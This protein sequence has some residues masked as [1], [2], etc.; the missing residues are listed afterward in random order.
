MGM[1][2]KMFEAT[3]KLMNNLGEFDDSPP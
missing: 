2:S 1:G 3:C